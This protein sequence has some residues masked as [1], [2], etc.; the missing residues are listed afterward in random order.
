[1][2]APGAAACTS[3]PPA[4]NLLANPAGSSR[5]HAC[6]SGTAL[7]HSRPPTHRVAALPPLPHH[8]P[9]LPRPAPPGLPQ[10]DYHKEHFQAYPHINSPLVLVKLLSQHQGDARLPQ[11]GS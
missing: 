1:M 7:L 6:T 9:S 5:L 10:A 4:P 3:I 2:A 8:A 11:L